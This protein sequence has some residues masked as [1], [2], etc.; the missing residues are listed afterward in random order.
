MYR[1]ISSSPFVRWS[2]YLFSCLLCMLALT[3]ISCSSGATASP[4]STSPTSQPTVVGTTAASSRKWDDWFTYH[5]DMTRTGYLASTPDPQHLTKAWRISLDGAVFA[6]PLMVKGHVIVAT[7]GDSLYALDPR[8]G[9][10]LWHT[11]IGTPVQRSTLPCG[12]IDPL[13]ITGTPVY[14]PATGLIFAVAEISGPQHVLIGVDAATGAV[15]LRRTVDIPGMEVDVHQQRAAL[16]LSHGMVYITYGGLAGD[17]GQYRGT[18][19][20]SQ[21]NGKGNLLSYQV[22][23]T[24]EGGIWTTPGPTI[25]KQGNVY[26]S[27]GNGEA[28][29]G[30]WDH[31]DS[32][33]RLSSQLQL[34][35]GFAPTQ[36]QQENSHDTDLGSMG[37]ALLSNGLIFIAGKSG[38][39]Y[40]VRAN[41]LGGV[42]GQLSETRVCDGM[43]MGGAS[44]VGSQVLIPCNDGVRRITVHNN[45]SVSVDW[46]ASNMVDP[47]IVGGHTVYGLDGG[48]TLYA[49]DLATGATRTS[50]SLSED[51]PHFAT[52][53]L[54]GTSLF[55]GTNNGIV[56]VNLS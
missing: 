53:M 36:W 48:G 23:V 7:E 17:C 29:S 10:V 40:V 31:S 41:A 56:A 1:E 3:L 38:S 43:A 55:V 51:V 6:E 35:D 24:R 13:G 21:T 12:D 4:V 42:G 32:V 19:V 22:P 34:Q 27:V 18:V 33:L 45:G 26:V 14:D 50:I 16:A 46:H 37:P 44:I 8:Q 11:N 54:S 28:T 2:R 25:D 52:P 49:V 39:G 20:A 30:D 9:S 15:K 47:A 5:H